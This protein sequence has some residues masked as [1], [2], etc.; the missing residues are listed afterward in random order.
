MTSDPS[1]PPDRKPPGWRL[2]WKPFRVAVLMV[3]LA[4]VSLWASSVKTRRELRR[5]WD[6]TLEVA[7]IVLGPGGVQQSKEELVRR[8]LPELEDFLASEF[9]RYRDTDLRPV[10]FTLLG[11]VGVS[12]DPPLFP[13]SESF[14]DRALHAWRLNRYLAD[15]HSRGDFDVRSYDARIYVVAKP[16][17]AREPRRVR[18]SGTLD[19]DLGLVWAELDESTAS[20]MLSGIAHELLHCV[21][22]SDKYDE[23]GHAIHPQG[24]AEPDLRPSYPQRYAE[25][26][27]GEIP[28]RPGHG[29]V[30]DRLDQLRV[31]PLTAAEIGWANA[32][33]SP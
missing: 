5:Q 3:L 9:Q 17:R 12:E 29:V 22:A 23:N 27:V 1:Q 16:T 19:G 13:D 31:G 24:L 7:V 2:R 8:G 21:G 4:S 28:I 18:G 33:A 14:K 25:I 30:P 15:V 32:P 20:L 6:R 10:S 26:M 11:S